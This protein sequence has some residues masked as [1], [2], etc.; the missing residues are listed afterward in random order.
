MSHE[1]PDSLS[2]FIDEI[3]GRQAKTLVLVNRTES[4]PLGRL[5]DRT[6]EN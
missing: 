5:L 1:L 4:Q 6:F 3:A 2:G